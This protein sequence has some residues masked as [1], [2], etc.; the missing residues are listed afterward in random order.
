M[1]LN[2][3]TFWKSLV[4][5][6]FIQIGA[7]LASIGL[8]EFLVPNKILD[9]GVVGISIMV[10]YLTKLPLGLFISILN[11]PFILLS[12]KRIGKKFVYYTIYAV[13]SLSLWVTFF[14]PIKEITND[15]F[16]A[17]VF[18]GIMLGIGVGLIIRNGGC[19][20][21]T[22]IIALIINKKISFSVGEIVMFFN[23]FIFG[24]AGFIFGIE[25]AL[26]SII[27]YLVA[28]KLIDLMVE[29]IDE[30]KSLF[31]VT[32]HTEIITE[33]IVSEMNSGVTILKGTGGYSKQEKDI[34]YLIVGRLEVNKVKDLVRSIDKNAFITVHNVHEVIGKNIKKRI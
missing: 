3:K 22:E 11:I 30:S 14:H 2:K 5:I 12:Y 7:V 13:I 1:S 27:V 24:I 20:D 25:R 21:G 4:N 17:T 19:L 28:Y 26:Y 18:G 34:V 33:K 9:G 23:I 15:L 31:I 10:S 29:G 8:E 6:L 32:D 16:L